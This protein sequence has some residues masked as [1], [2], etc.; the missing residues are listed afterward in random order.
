MPTPADPDPALSSILLPV[1][2]FVAALFVFAILAY[3]HLYVANS[4]PARKAT[5][6]LLFLNGFMLFPLLLFALSPPHVL[7]FLPK[8]GG[9]CLLLAVVSYFATRFCPNC[10]RAI[11]ERSSGSN[12]THCPYCGH[13]YGDSSSMED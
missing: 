12:F 3:L 6:A 1:G 7:P 9:V 10:G 11:F 2:L 8:I 4:L 5:V 13:S